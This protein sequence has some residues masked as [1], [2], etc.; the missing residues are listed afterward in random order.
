[1]DAKH[2]LAYAHR[3]A[4]AA[5]RH[6]A[7]PEGSDSGLDA[8]AGRR[9]VT[10]ALRASKGVKQRR[11][12]LTAA[13]LGEA[14][15]VQAAQSG[16]CQQADGETSTHGSACEAAVLSEEERRARKRAKKLAQK[17]RHEAEGTDAERRAKEK[18]RRARKKSRLKQE[19][20]ARQLVTNHGLK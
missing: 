4:A 2:I 7:E 10:R 5:Q 9:T 19:S 15:T 6:V 20:R 11:K 12:K 13:N 17:Q 1:M 14:C 3:A 8:K 16:S 18:A